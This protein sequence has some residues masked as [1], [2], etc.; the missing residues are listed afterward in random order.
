MTPAEIIRAAVAHRDVGRVPYTFAAEDSVL[1]R[2]DDYYG[3]PGWRDR[4][5]RYLAFP[6]RVDTRQERPIDDVH[7]AD[8]Y[9]SIWRTDKRPWHLEQPALVESSLQGY[10]IPTIE[11]FVEPIERGIDGACRVIASDPEHFQVIDMG[12][13]I[14]EQ[15]WRIRGY[16]NA[17]MDAV[18]EPEFYRDLVHEIT[19]IY[20]AIVRACRPVPADAFLFG[21][22]WGDQRGVILGPDRW[23]D[24]IRPAWQAI[25]DEVHS[26]GKIVMS[27]SCGS[28]AD[29]MGDIIDIGMDV[30][31]SVQPEAAGMNPYDLKKR[32]GDRITFWG[33]LGSQSTIPFGSEEDVRAEIH[34]LRAEVG[35]GGGY[36]MAPAKPLQP[37]T[38]IRNAI[39]IVEA[40]AEL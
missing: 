21:D 7:A 25:Y 35:R 26:Q 23:R 14:F 18:A 22:D 2:L 6:L 11:R 12:W 1:Q 27:H 33:C 4:L 17:L 32:W 9:G 36:I 16:E 15:T 39:A 5:T 40:F 13:G 10:R 20:L 30:L 19:E 37:E 28:V 38:P 8:A 29:I 3:S 34:R 24:F 31:E